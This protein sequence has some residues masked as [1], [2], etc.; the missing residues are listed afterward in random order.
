M[1]CLFEGALQIKEHI[2]CCLKSTFD[3]VLKSTFDGALMN[4]IG[5]S[6]LEYCIVEAQKPENSCRIVV[7]DLSHFSS[8][9]NRFSDS[10]SIDLRPMDAQAYGYLLIATDESASVK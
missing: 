4:R 10:A 2:R 8:V 7:Y 6:T 3:D 9:A 5:T 1:A